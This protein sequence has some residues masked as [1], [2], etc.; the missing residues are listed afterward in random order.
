[1]EEAVEVRGWK[2]RMSFPEGR[3]EGGWGEGEGERSWKW[4]LKPVA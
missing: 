4:A 2:V 1:M 3:E